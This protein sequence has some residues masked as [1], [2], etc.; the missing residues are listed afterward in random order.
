MRWRPS[1]RPPRIG[2]SNSK[3]KRTPL[4]SWPP[5]KCAS[6]PTSASSPWRRKS[7][8][9]RRWPERWISAEKIALKIAE[10]AKLKKLE[11]VDPANI[12]QAEQALADQRAAFAAAELSGLRAVAAERQ[13][14]LERS[15]R[16]G[17]TSVAEYQA[18]V[19]E[20]LRLRV[21]DQRQADELMIAS[22]DNMSA[23]LSLGW[24]RSMEKMKTDAEVMIEIGAML[25]EQLAGGM[26]S[27]FDSFIEGSKTAKEAFMDFARSTLN[28][29]AQIIMKQM[30][31][32]A[33]KSFG[34]GMA[35]G[36]PVQKLASGGKVHGSSPNDR[37]DNVPI[38]ATAGEFMH[39][40]RAV[41]KYG[42]GFMEAVRSLRFPADLARSM[43]MAAMPAPRFSLPASFHLASG[44][45]VPRAPAAAANGGNS[46]NLQ[47]IN[48]LDQGLVGDYLSSAA[49][50]TTIINMIRR[51]GTTIKA[52]LG[53]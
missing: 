19:R 5:K 18:A 17:S 38:W 21:I 12:I 44:G 9:P 53:G 40:V 8:K 36:G 1:A 24:S 52:L 23:A 50:E 43:A 11:G 3:K 13:Q 35:D 51:N 25:P 7:S 49:G 27:A 32:N 2:W 6:P 47:V 26:T 15:W 14:T 29:I 39:P 33:L 20:S 48:V 10:L 46:T 37:A 22:G 4:I 41:Q 42:I 34:W 16:A 28:M 30:I 31:L 45:A